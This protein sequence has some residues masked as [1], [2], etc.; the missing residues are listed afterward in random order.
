M[1]A[2]KMHSMVK[3][4]FHTGSDVVVRQ[5]LGLSTC[6]VEIMMVFAK[7]QRMRNTRGQENMLVEREALTQVHWKIVSRPSE[8]GTGAEIMARW[9][10]LFWNE[11]SLYLRF[12]LGTKVLQHETILWLELARGKART[13]SCVSRWIGFHTFLA[14]KAASRASPAIQPSFSDV[15]LVSRPQHILCQGLT[16]TLRAPLWTF[17]WLDSKPN[18]SGAEASHSLDWIKIF[19]PRALN[20]Y[21]ETELALYP[22]AET[23]LVQAFLVICSPVSSSCTSWAGGRRRAP[24]KQGRAGKSLVTGDTWNQVTQPWS[25]LIIFP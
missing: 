13:K 15:A 1:C 2:E 6:D 20:G 18:F 10:G 23:A 11:S 4:L 21:A 9:A 12:I 24:G 5:E 22:M 7:D 16:S 17:Q 8:L 25:L 19:Y 14:P 3:V